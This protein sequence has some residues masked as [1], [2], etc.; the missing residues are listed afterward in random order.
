MFVVNSLLKS[1]G[2]LQKSPENAFIPVHSHVRPRTRSSVTMWHLPE[3]ICLHLLKHLHIKDLL[4]M[5]IVHPYFN[6]LINDNNCLWASVKF[7]NCWPSPA[8]LHH[9]QRAANAGNVESLV[10]LGVAYLYHEGLPCDADYQNITINGTTAAQLFSEIETMNLKIEPFT[11]LFI[12]PPW[13]PSGACCKEQVFTCMKESVDSNPDKQLALCVAKTL[14]LMENEERQSESK[15][16]LELSARLGSG[17]AA[18][19]L[20]QQKFSNKCL[21]TAT[22]LTSIRELRDVTSMGCLDASLTLCDFYSRGIYGGIHRSQAAAYMKETFQSSV[23]SGTHKIF[24]SS[25]NLSQAMRY[26]LVDWLVEVAGMKSFSNQ[27]LHT[28]VSVVDRFLA[29][30]NVPRAKLQLLGVAA[31]VVCSRFLGKDVITVREAAWLTDNTYKYED[32]VRMMGEITASLK[33]NIRIATNL[34]YVKVVNVLAGMDAKA[35]CLAEYICELCVLQSEMGQ[36]SPTE[37]ACSSV[38]LARLLL[39][40]EEPW[41]SQ[42]EEFTGF[43]LEDLSRCA[44]HIHEKCFLEGSVIDHREITL[45]AVKQKY[46]EEK[47]FQVSSIEIMNYE[48]LCSMLGVTDFYLNGFDL[49][50]RF[51]NYDELIVSPCRGKSKGRRTAQ[52]FSEREN[53][54]TPSFEKG[55]FFNDSMTSGYEG[56]QEDEDSMFDDSFSPIKSDS[57]DLAFDSDGDTYSACLSSYIQGNSSYGTIPDSFDVSSPPCG[58]NFYC[59]NSSS[60]G[61]SC[62]PVTSSPYSKKAKCNFNGKI[63]DVPIF[64]E[65]SIPNTSDNKRRKSARTATKMTSPNALKRKKRSSTDTSKSLCD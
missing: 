8:N 50:L 51:R 11:W 47:F 64:S 39:K 19:L 59:G 46:G 27:T 32:V 22:E 40:S 31:M 36:Y 54:A 37:I 25:T 10:K 57:S 49:K 42:M 60:S 12:R 15:Q 4:N 2:Q 53:A 5:K 44:F 35:S 21:D 33:G 29:T 24:K 30:Q 6:D 61:V 55:P 63:S 43:P 48:E 28:A 3:E 7:H 38:L 17:S 45:Q 34:D 13:S 18:Y 58:T 56:D 65:L 1:L 20:W 41:P 62:S 52:R 16:Y 23:P 9:F 14:Q 26:I